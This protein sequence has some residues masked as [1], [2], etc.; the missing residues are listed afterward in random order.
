[1]E[2]R[3]KHDGRCHCGNVRYRYY[4][5]QPAAQLSMRACSCSYCRKTGA[6][7]S[8]DPCGILVAEVGD[9]DAIHLYRFGTQTADFYVCS[10]C[11]IAPFVIWPDGADLY[12]LVNVNTFDVPLEVSACRNVCYAHE[13]VAGRCARRRRQWIGNVTLTLPG[14]RRV[15]DFAVSS[16][17]L[18]EQP[19]A[20]G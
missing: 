11:G 19:V 9:C 1:M 5:S 6:R 15:D 13:D 18:R 14:H 12:A 8:A 17:V 3:H 16:A 20:L 2:T 10:K 4:S 7:Y